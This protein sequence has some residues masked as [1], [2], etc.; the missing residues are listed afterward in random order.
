[1]GAGVTI[2][3]FG[4]DTLKK[5]LQTVAQARRIRQ[6]VAEGTALVELTAK[7]LCP[8]DTGNLASSIHMDMDT[9]EPIG[10]VY[11][12]CEYA[13]YVEFGTGVAGERSGY[14]KA[15]ELGLSYASYWAG[16]VAQPFM[17]PALKQNKMRIKALIDNA[18]RKE[19]R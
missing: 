11:T 14:E 6:A 16:Q 19:I 7:K 13:P 10:V 4:V 17:L 8:R 1:M 18:V 5:K 9:T 2:E 3:V 15:G 12:S